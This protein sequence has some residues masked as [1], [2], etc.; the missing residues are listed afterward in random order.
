MLKA[1]PGKEDITACSQ[2][3]QVELA[4]LLYRRVDHCLTYLALVKE[5]RQVSW[6]SDEKDPGR[7]MSKI[8]IGQQKTYSPDGLS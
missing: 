3:K 4:A 2:R 1:H 7:A 6:K 5:Q 8:Y